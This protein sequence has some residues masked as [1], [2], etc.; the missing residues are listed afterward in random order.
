MPHRKTAAVLTIL[1]AGASATAA[2]IL[3]PEPPRAAAGSVAE[4]PPLPTVLPAN[5]DEKLQTDDLLK[6]AEAE[7]SDAHLIDALGRM[8]ERKHADWV[9]VIRKNIE[10]ADQD[11]SSAAIRAAASHDLRD[12]EKRVRKIL[13]AKPKDKNAKV[14]GKIAAACIDYLGRLGFGGEEEYVF[15]EQLRAL[16]GDE[17]RMKQPWS[18]EMVRACIHYLGKQKYKPCVP[19]MIDEMLG[20]P[21]PENPNDPKNPPA[22]YWEARHKSW[23]ESEGW[24]RWLLKEIAGQ[25]YRTVREW[26]AWLKL[27]K[28][29]FEKKK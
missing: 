12:E 27:N 10:A 20:E 23:Q 22:S 7:K 1:L 18:A 19:F 24:V 16:I 2:A 29:D 6:K 11:I 14:P 3:L 21:H 5:A 13:R 9:P 15:E 26:Q 25:E 28:K 4:E 17:R 8:M